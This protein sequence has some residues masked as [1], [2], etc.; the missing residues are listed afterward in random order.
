ME[1]SV[2]Q[3]SVDLQRLL[4]GLG[5]ILELLNSL[6]LSP[7]CHHLHLEESL[8]GRLSHLLSLGHLGA[9]VVLRESACLTGFED[10]LLGLAVGDNLVTSE[11]LDSLLGEMFVYIF[12]QFLPG[13]EG[14]ELGVEDGECEEVEGGQTREITHVHFIASFL[15]WYGFGCHRLY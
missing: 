5:F 9:G 7:P 12:L 11:D 3:V 6:L 2:E 14:E 4:R 8:K 1:N 15:A 10:E 13:C